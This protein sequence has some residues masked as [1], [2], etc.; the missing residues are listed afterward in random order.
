MDLLL[1]YHVICQPILDAICAALPSTGRAGQGQASQSVPE[2]Q[3]RFRCTE[4]EQL[5]SET[6]SL[7]PQSR[8]WA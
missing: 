5:S 3:T 7:V 6:L 1:Q 4:I 8:A 2:S